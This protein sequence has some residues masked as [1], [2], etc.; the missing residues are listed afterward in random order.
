LSRV[1]RCKVCS[2]Y[3]QYVNY[4]P[5][6]VGSF[7]PFVLN[8]VSR[9]IL[10]T[11]PTSD[12]DSLPDHSHS[13]PLKYYVQREEEISQ[14]SLWSKEGFW[15]DALLIGLKAQMDM[16]DPVLWDELDGEQLKEKVL[17]IN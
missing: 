11:H 12:D 4:I 8:V 10:D 2:S 15:E 5:H 1:K 7:V 14:H 13:S 6:K 3:C 16:M 17:G 9:N